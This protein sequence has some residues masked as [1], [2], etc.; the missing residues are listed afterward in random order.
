MILLL[1]TYLF[2]R[3]GHKLKLKALLQKS[4]Y[5]MTLQPVMAQNGSATQLLK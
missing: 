4:Q 3:F 1:L 5:S 2:K